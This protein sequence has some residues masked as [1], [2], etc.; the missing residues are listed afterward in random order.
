M[1]SYENILVEKFILF[2]SGDIPEIFVVTDEILVKYDSNTWTSKIINS[3]VFPMV[4]GAK[5]IYF[6]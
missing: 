1:S 2:S 4:Y 3:D 6:S 5:R